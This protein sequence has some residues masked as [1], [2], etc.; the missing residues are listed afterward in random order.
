MGR[1]GGEAVEVGGPVA[2][3]RAAQEGVRKPWFLIPFSVPASD[4]WTANFGATVFRCEIPQGY[5]PYGLSH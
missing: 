3:T 5:Q 2:R 4:T 1:A